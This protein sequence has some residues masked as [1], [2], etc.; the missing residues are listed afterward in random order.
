MKTF[1]IIVTGMAIC[2]FSLTAKSQ[3]NSNPYNGLATG[4]SYNT[5]VGL[6]AGETSGLTIKHF[7]NSLA[8]EGILGA[9]NHGFSA[10]LLI[11][12]HAPAFG[13]TGMN[14]YYGGGGHVA[15]QST[16]Y[17]KYYDRG[18]YKLYHDG[19]VGVGVDGVVGLEYK[20][21]SVPFAI[22]LDVKPYLEVVSNGGVWTS[23][24]PGLG[25]KLT[26]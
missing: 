19:S 7:K 9:W 18:R 6:R 24:D 1:K 2:L 25:V 26:F 14:W 13:I 10:T 3:L 15:F 23:L 21:P 22:S 4:S 12:K 11:E 16:Y 17:H 20:I 5:A 8:F